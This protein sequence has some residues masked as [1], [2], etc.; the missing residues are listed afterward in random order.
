[1]KF[2]TKTIAMAIFLF[3]GI[4][5]A[6]PVASDPTQEFPLRPG[7]SWIY[8][9][10]VRWTAA[11]TN[12]VHEKSIT[13]K[14][15]VRSV[16]R[17]NNLR[18]AVVSGFPSELVWADEN[19]SPSEKLLI[20][21]SGGKIF[22]TDLTDSTR[23][24]LND[25]KETFQDLLKDENLFLA[26]PLFRGKKFCDGEGMSRTDGHYCW[27][28]ES[29]KIQPAVTSK[30][31]KGF[32]VAYRTNPDDISYTFVSGIGITAYAYHHHGTVAETEVNLV[33]FHEASSPAP[34]GKPKP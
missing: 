22:I 26:L 15:Q 11:G 10:F 27:I 7:C 3:L 19:T 21:T 29:E 1:M 6:A 9:G 30:N 23:R 18:I 8:K 12:L 16:E 4:T 25:P 24:R 17:R 2:S 32:E 14:M 28:V 20:Q 5:N 33:D 13:W 34:N 31:L